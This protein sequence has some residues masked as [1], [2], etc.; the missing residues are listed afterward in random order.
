MKSNR[1]D[2]CELLD[3]YKIILGGGG[4][5]VVKTGDE[6]DDATA[7]KFLKSKM[8]PSA[9]KEYIVARKVYDAYKIFLNCKKVPN[10]SV[11]KPYNFIQ[12]G[13]SA[14]PDGKYSCALIM[15]RLFSPIDDGYAVHL[16]LNGQIHWSSM[17]KVLYS[18]GVPRGYFYGPIHV[19]ELLSQGRGLASLEQ[20]TY[21]IG[22]LDGIVI[23][24]AGMI[25]VDVEYI[26][27]VKN[28]EYYVSLIDVGLFVPLDVSNTNVEDLAMYISE[29]QDN[30]LYYHPYSD[31]IP[32]ETSG[33]C[34]D[35][36]IQG[37]N[38]AYGCFREINGN[39]Y[40]S[41]HFHLIKLYT[42]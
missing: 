23:F 12:N 42:S 7:V 25:P 1:L 30:N 3:R 35:A 27:T 39:A 16:A 41:L 38:D 21:R 36:F 33:L 5:G 11:V 9:K 31:A 40:D 34:R 29:L 18:N 17:N 26:L 20:V 6:L 19:K 14:C 15:E 13:N 37:I 24:G 2:I 8:C 28:K 10:F 4:Y 32:S 22:L